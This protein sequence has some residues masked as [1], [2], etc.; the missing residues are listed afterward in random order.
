MAFKHLRSY[1]DSAQLMQWYFDQCAA[2]QECHAAD[3]GHD[4]P[5]CHSIQTQ[6]RPV[7]VLSIDVER[8]TG[9]HNYPFKCLWS[10]PTTYE[11]GVL[12]QCYHDGIQR[13]FQ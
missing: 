7:V 3:R 10:D 8:H 13:E 2:T 1:R 5:P 9:S 6:G 12:F 11:A 4:A